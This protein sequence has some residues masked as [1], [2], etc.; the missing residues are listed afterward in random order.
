MI[1]KIKA[2]EPLLACFA[3]RPDLN[4]AKAHSVSLKAR[5]SYFVRRSVFS[6]AER[7]RFRFAKNQKRRVRF[8]VAYRE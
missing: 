7:H 4:S 1:C 8:G 6:M 2:G 3:F 5:E